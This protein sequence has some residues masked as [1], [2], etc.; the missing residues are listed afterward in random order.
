MKRATA[1]LGLGKCYD[2]A[3]TARKKDVNF[4]YPNGRLVEIQSFDDPCLQRDLWSPMPF[5]RIASQTRGGP[6]T[7]LLC[8][9]KDLFA[10]M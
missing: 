1:L 2:M 5:R 4:R 10:D 8:F 7:S 9:R 3:G 6:F